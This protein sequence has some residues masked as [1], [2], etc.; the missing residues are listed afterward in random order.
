MPLT[1][2]QIKRNAKILRKMEGQPWPFRQPRNEAA[3]TTRQVIEEGEPILTVVHDAETGLWQ[4]LPA[5]TV[6]KKDLVFVALSAAYFL[7]DRTIGQVA[8]LPLG[9]HAERSA[10][11][12]P[13]QVFHP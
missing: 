4:F 13:W 2:K 11:G 5:G 6:D 9:W 3:L 12:Q 10:V 7:N 1:P 8:K